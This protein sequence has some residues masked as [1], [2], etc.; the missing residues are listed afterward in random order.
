MMGT[1][2]D[3]ITPWG[4]DMNVRASGAPQDGL[5][6]PDVADAGALEYLRLI[7]GQLWPAPNVV[8]LEGRG[9]RRQPAGSRA[10]TR[11]PGWTDTGY[12]LVPGIGR[13]PLLARPRTASPPRRSATSTAS[14][15]SR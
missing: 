4:P 8:T 5:V 13:P 15:R 14:E 10:R 1:T 6:P 3:D 2:H 9:L 12:A 7:C 11:P